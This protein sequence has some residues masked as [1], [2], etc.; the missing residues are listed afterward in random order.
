MTEAVSPL[1]FGAAVTTTLILAALP[2]APQDTPLPD[3]F[4]DVIDVRVVNVE[5]VVTDRKGNRIRGLEASDFELRVDGEPV[6]IEYFTE[7]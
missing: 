3:L 2:A 6:P 1:R 5:V 4:A 7:I